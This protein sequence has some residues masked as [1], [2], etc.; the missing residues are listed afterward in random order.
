MGLAESLTLL[1]I[2]RL[3][4]GVGS[5]TF[6]TCNAHIAD[7]TSSEER[8]QY[9]GMMGAAFGPGFVIGPVLG[10]FLGSLGR[11]FRFLSPLRWSC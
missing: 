10:G 1:F 5:A 6:S 7:R 4:S 2:G 3:L 11:G 8:A 9:F